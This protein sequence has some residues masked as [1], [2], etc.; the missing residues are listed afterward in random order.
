MNVR[1]LTAPPILAP[2]TRTIG[3][4]ADALAAIALELEPDADEFTEE[5][6]G[7]LRTARL[8]ATNAAAI[9]YA[10]VERQ[11]LGPEVARLREGCVCGCDRGEH[12]ADVGDGELACDGCGACLGFAPESAR[13]DVLTSTDRAPEPAYPLD[14]PEPEAV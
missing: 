4:T 6:R 14:E 9:L 5:E 10:L 11:M 13:V 1:I 8:L 3:E 7:T 12:R 2:A